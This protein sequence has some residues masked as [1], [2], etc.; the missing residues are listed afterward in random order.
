MICVVVGQR[1][2]KYCILECREHL[3]LLV[4][5]NLW[6]TQNERTTFKTFSVRLLCTAQ[7][8]QCHYYLENHS[9][10]LGD[11]ATFPLA[12]FVSCWMF[13][14]SSEGL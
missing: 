5:T 14:H 6:Y 7:L 1:G 11:K 10:H 12:V 3:N 2:A 4:Y 9:T 8:S 13:L